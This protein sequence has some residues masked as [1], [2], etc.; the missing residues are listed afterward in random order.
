[1]ANLSTPMGDT[2]KSDE[3]TRFNSLRIWYIQKIASCLSGLWKYVGTI[4]VFLKIGVN[5]DISDMFF[6]NNWQP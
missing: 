1:M 4:Y 2:W 6:I 5:Q 3:N